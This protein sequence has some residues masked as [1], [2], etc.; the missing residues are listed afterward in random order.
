FAV[1]GALFMFLLPEAKVEL[2]PMS[3]RAS[4]RQMFFDPRKH[5]DFTILWVGKFLMQTA[6]TFLSTYQLYF[7]LDRLG[8]TAETAGSR[9]ALVGG[10]GILVTMTFAVGSGIISDRLQRRRLF[11]LLAGV[12][13]L[14]GMV[15][16]AFA[17]G[18]G[19]FVAAVLV[20]VG[21]AGMFGSVDVALAS[22]LIPEP[23]RAGK[24]MT[25]YNVASGVAT[26]VDPLAGALL[27]AIG[28][29]GANY[30]A[31][32]LAGAVVAVLAG[33]LT[34]AIRQVR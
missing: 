13:T 26:A 28:G 14:V 3:I 24:W 34:T 8:F 22:D 21:A 1:L 2:E 31:L 30:T 6:L 33:V 11:I 12:L 15:I 5:R 32:F 18:F 17:S 29:G 27:L 25:T 23:A 16:M 7:L 4:F 19:L 20:I 10:L 9:L